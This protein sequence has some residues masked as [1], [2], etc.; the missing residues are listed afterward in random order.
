MRS[1]L[2][3]SLPDAACRQLSLLRGGLPA[4]RWLEPHNLHLTLLFMGD[5]RD[6]DLQELDWHLQGL[7]LP[8]FDFCLQDL[9]CFDRSGLC[10][11]L[12][13]GVAP[14]QELAV[15]AKELRRLAQRLGIKHDGKTFYPHVT[16]ARFAMRPR[17][18]LMPWIEE[19]ATLEL[20]CVDAKEFHLYSSKLTAEGAEYR[21]E[22]SYALQMARG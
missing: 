9:G 22:A 3:L 6:D 12:W 21:I 18:E 15:L 4:A 7:D 5:L 11:S 16:L 2:G 19:R 10:N 17:V 13:A 1:F 8:S 20:P 14:C